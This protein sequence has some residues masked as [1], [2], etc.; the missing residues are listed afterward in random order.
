M[1]HGWS[2]CK[3]GRPRG[4]ATSSF[5]DRDSE[6][7]KLVRAAPLTQ[8]A[9]GREWRACYEVPDALLDVDPCLGDVFFWAHCFLG[10][11]GA[12]AHF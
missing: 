3:Q 8:V 12:E 1:S 6:K 2:L 4:R 7:E 5:R 9:R 11:L 10:T